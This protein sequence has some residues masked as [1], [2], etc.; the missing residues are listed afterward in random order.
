M[1]P[2]LDIRKAIVI[3]T[4]VLIV[5]SIAALSY[6]S[7]VTKRQ[8][9]ATSNPPKRQDSDYA[10]LITDEFTAMKD[11]SQQPIFSIVSSEKLED[12][13]YKVTIENNVGGDQLYTLVHDAKYG[14]Q[15]MSLV[16]PPSVHFSHKENLTSIFIPDK[17]IRKMNCAKEGC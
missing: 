16:L 11:S 15:G 9:M 10:K 2:T 1:T 12:N 4:I 3:G 7:I 17:I 14:P 13:W 5:V 6:P 8:D